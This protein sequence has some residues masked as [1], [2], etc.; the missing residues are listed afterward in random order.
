M[1][2]ERKVELLKQSYLHGYAAECA[3]MDCIIE[4]FKLKN[5]PPEKAEKAISRLYQNFGRIQYHYDNVVPFCEITLEMRAE[6]RDD[7]AILF[8]VRE[9]LPKFKRFIDE[10]IDYLRKNKYYTPEE[11]GILR[12]FDDIHAELFDAEQYQGMNLRARILKYDS[13]FKSE[14]ASC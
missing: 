11:S 1:E 6:D 9:I 10:Y 4:L 2:L 3:G 14:P 12:R 8:R 5:I 13:A 7:F